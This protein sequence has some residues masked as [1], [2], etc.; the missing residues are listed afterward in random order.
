MKNRLEIRPAGRVAANQLAPHLR[1]ADV[2]EIHASSGMAPLEALL[3]SIAV[4]DEDLCFG[5]FVDGLPICMFGA[6][7]LTEDNVV[8]GIWLLGSPRINDHPGDFMRRCREYL[9]I[10]HER[11]EYLTNFIDERNLP[12]MRWLPYLGF[13]PCQRVADYGYAKVPFVQYVSQRQ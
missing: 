2:L 12:T 5:A 4:S 8:G 7:Q 10:M 3:E 6:N 1:I 11:Y 13:R 9:A